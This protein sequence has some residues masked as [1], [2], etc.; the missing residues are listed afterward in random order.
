MR[1]FSVRLR[2]ETVNCKGFKVSQLDTDRL[3]GRGGSLGGGVQVKH[4]RRGS[5]KRRQGVA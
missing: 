5:S 2:L 1:V 4:G 3:E